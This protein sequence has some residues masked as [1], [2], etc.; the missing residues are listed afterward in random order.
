M[1]KVCIIT[2]VHDPFDSR[3]FH[4]QASALVKAGYDV[5]LMAVHKQEETVNGIKIVPLPMISNRIQRMKSGLDIFFQAMDEKADVYHIHDPELLPT[6]RKLG[7]AGKNVIFDSHELYPQVLVNRDYIPKI[8]QK[9]VA[10]SYRLIEKRCIP[11]LK[12]IIAAFPAILEENY[13]GYN[14][15]K[16]VIRNLPTFDLFVPVET[17]KNIQPEIVYF[18]R[19]YPTRGMI[20]LLKG[21]SLALKSVPDLKVRFIGR[22]D[23]PDF[24]EEILNFASESGL[25]DALELHEHVP[26]P[27]LKEFLQ[28][29]LI[30][31]LLL[32]P[33]YNHKKTLPNKLF[34]YMAGGLAVISSDLPV[35]RSIIEETGCGLVV[36]HRRPENVAGA[37][38]N[39]VRD[40][41]KTEKMM[42]NGQKA[43]LNEYNWDRE[44]G[45]L[46][47]FYENL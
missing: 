37:I 39:L 24:R 2:S 46:V 10:L 23:P 40:K 16:A 32:H 36:D 13:S 22:I 27:R 29:A 21:A 38:I 8:L 25:K 1:N 18:G 26:Y 5:T 42:L 34:E 30:G 15:K 4:K 41:E 6:G 11:R 12:G 20:D 35:S 3:I 9:P 28:K 17:K 31:S 43:F 33:T 47:E 7:K 14:V 44:S 45:K 19:I